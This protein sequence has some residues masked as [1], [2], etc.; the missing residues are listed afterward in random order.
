VNVEDLNNRETTKSGWKIVTFA[1]SDFE[2][3][4]HYIC[5]RNNLGVVVNK[6]Q[7]RCIRVLAGQLFVS[8]DEGTATVNTG[9]TF[10]I[11]KGVEYA[12]AT[13]GTTDCEVLFC[14]GKDYDSNM[15]QITPATYNASLSALVAPKQNG[16][17]PK[18]RSDSKAQDQAA[19]IGASRRQKREQHEQIKSRAPLPGQT[20]V[21]VNPKP[22]G[23]TG[24]GD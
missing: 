15:D 10:G 8:T 20:V 3:V 19:Q 11:K 7:E 22:V 18:R 2:V 23:S 13:S 1:G 4:Y 24:Y 5:A 6:D 12:L 14:Q 17:Q 16:D 21:G 9:R